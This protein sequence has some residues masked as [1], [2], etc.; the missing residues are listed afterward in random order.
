M[1]PF[2]VINLHK[3][4]CHAGF[5]V[6]YLFW[7]FC[8]CVFEVFVGGEGGGVKERAGVGWWY[9]PALLISQ[10]ASGGLTLH[11]NLLTSY[12]GLF[13]K[14]SRRCRI[15][16]CC[17]LVS[18]HDFLFF[19]FTYPSLFW[20]LWTLWRGPSTFGKELVVI[21]TPSMR[22]LTSRASAIYC[23]IH[24]TSVGWRLWSGRE[25]SSGP[26][27]WSP[28]PAADLSFARRPDVW[29]PSVWKL[30]Y[31]ESKGGGESCIK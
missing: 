6:L 19:V 28:R 11:N 8:R 18:F 29:F 17:T 31:S 3:A 4:T 12:G 27:A 30:F 26:A 16:F 2:V 10:S 13:I 23:K 22:T 25:Q 14:S 9:R 5:Y 24:C 7:L 20:L 15:P 21:V 1:P